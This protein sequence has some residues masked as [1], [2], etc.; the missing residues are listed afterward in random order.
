M[1]VKI[2]S[3]TAGLQS[4]GNSGSARNCGRVVIQFPPGTDTTDLQSRGNSI[5]T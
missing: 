1:R 2:G 4:R 5:S 3:D